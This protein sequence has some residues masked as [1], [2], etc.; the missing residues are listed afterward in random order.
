MKS[1]EEMQQSFNVSLQDRFIQVDFLAQ[2]IPP[3]EN[4]QRAVAAVSEVYTILDAS[5]KELFDVLVVMSEMGESIIPIKANKI[6][7]QALRR[8]Q[9][10]HVAIVGD[11]KKQVKVL[12]FITPFIVGRGKKVVWFPNKAEALLWLEKE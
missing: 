3:K 2:I 5:P 10:R 4:I 8:D 6:Y 12:S 1:D 7:L 11:F 9:I